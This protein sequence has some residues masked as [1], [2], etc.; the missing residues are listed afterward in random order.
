MTPGSAVVVAL[1]ATAMVG[2]RA[3]SFSSTYRLDSVSGNTNSL[4]LNSGAAVIDV[5]SSNTQELRVTVFGGASRNADLSGPNQLLASFNDEGTHQGGIATIGQ[6]VCKLHV[7]TFSA[8]GMSG[9][10]D[11]QNVAPLMGSSAPAG[12]QASIQA[13]AAAG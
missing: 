6:G 1:T 12:F 9:T 4:V 7:A 5:G 3:G 11:C 8:Q 10:L 13:K 2:F